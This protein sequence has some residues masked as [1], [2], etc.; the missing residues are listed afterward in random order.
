MEDVGDRAV[1]GDEALALLC[2]LE[3]DHASFSPTN[4]QMRILRPIVQTLMRTM[5]N[6]WHDFLFGC[7]V[8][9]ELIGDHDTRYD[10]LALQELSHQ[11]QGRSLV[12]AA[13]DQSLKN[14]TISSDSPP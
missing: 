12:P 4:G 10:A 2:R 9:S 5:L 6:T 3:P 11:L 7:V 8:G 1:H 13:L 14:I